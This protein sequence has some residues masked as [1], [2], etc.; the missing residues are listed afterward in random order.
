MQA[1]AF[2]QNL[3]RMIWF[4]LCPTGKQ[5]VGLVAGLANSIC[6]VDKL[7]G[8]GCMHIFVMF[9]QKFEQHW[10]EFKHWKKRFHVKCCQIWFSIYGIV[11]CC[12]SYRKSIGS[13]F[14]FIT[15]RCDG[16][17][18]WLIRFDRKWCW[19]HLIRV[20]SCCIVIATKSIDRLVNTVERG[21]SNNGIAMA[22][23]TFVQ[24][25]KT[26]SRTA[27]GVWC[28]LQIYCIH[29]ISKQKQQRIQLLR[30]SISDINMWL[31]FNLH[32]VRDFCTRLFS[33]GH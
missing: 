3:I 31:I 9:E 28:A 5:G 29:F 21:R 10:S 11:I 23:N 2:T 25:W 15:V 16:W 18:C 6:S 13:A 33:L 26:S 32:I 14:D 17:R 19:W 4:T 27:F 22:F 24:I 1:I 30:I 20:C 7:F 8:V 12:Y